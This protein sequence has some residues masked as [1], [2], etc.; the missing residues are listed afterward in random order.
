MHRFYRPT[1]LLFAALLAGSCVDNTGA[2]EPSDTDEAA[3]EV[4]P[5]ATVRDSGTS[6]KGHDAGSSSS[7]RATADAASAPTPTKDD[8]SQAEDPP[9]V[10][11]AGK[12]VAQADA[13]KADGGK[14]D[15]GK[16]DAGGGSASACDS[17]TYASFGKGFLDKYCISCHAG[18]RAQSGVA[19]DTLAGVQSSK[20]K[21][22]SEV[23]NSSMPPLFQTAPSAAERTQ[24]GMWIDCGP[25]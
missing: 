22:K 15:A 23:A 13:G 25:K 18:A 3:T 17:L 20:A 21:T 24:F 14:A 16:A 12:G 2:G 1:S 4:E 7:G 6:T 10:V 19:L 11:D 8:T 9:E 5:A